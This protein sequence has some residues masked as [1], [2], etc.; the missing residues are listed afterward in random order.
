MPLRKYLRKMLKRKAFK[1]GYD[2]VRPC[3]FREEG[4][5][6]ANL[7]CPVRNRNTDEV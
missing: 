6:F 1:K 7:N 2:H 5:A 3:N 4:F